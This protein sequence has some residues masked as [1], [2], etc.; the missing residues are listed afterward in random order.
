[1]YY[2]SYF[3]KRILHLLDTYYETDKD[4]TKRV[5]TRNIPLWNN[6]SLIDVAGDIG[7]KSFIAKQG[8][9]MVLEEQWSEVS[10]QINFSSLQSSKQTLNT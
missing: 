5:L 8:C 6:K 4:K 2:F 3:E 9:Q 10:F 7:L 1:M